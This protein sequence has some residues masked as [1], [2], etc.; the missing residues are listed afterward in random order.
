MWA[1]HPSMNPT[2]T[3]GRFGAVDTIGMSPANFGRIG[4]GAAFV[5]TNFVVASVTTMQPVSK[6]KSGTTIRIG[7]SFAVARLAPSGCDAVGGAPEHHRRRPST[8]PP[9]ADACLSAERES[10]RRRRAGRGPATRRSS[11]RCRRD[12][13]PRGGL[14]CTPGPR[15]KSDACMA[16]RSGS[17]P[18]VAA[19]AAGDS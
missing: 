3:N 15:S 5:G 1:G 19:M 4:C 7:T 10:A 18:C 9:G 2:S 14:S 16:G 17:Y 11:G 8:L 6:L 12:G 13:P